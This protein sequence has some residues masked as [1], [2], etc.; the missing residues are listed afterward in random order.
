MAH[1][2]NR[3]RTAHILCAVTT[4]SAAPTLAQAEEQPPAP[5]VVDFPAL[6]LPPPINGLIGLP[7]TY[8]KAR[9]T[10]LALITREAEQ[11]GLPPALADAVVKV[12]SGF[13]PFAVGGIGEVG[14]M[15]VRPETAAMLGYQ[16]GATGLFDPETNVRLGVAY[17]ARAWQLANGDVCRALM[18]YRAGW[19]EERMTPF[20]VEYCRRARVHLAAIGS[21]LADE[22]RPTPQ[23]PATVVVA[24]P[25]QKLSPASSPG[26]ARLQSAAPQLAAAKQTP[27]EPVP[28]P[29]IRLASLGATAPAGDVGQTR[30]EAP[31]SNGAATDNNAARQQASAPRV[32]PP[33]IGSSKAQPHPPLVSMAKAEP[34][35]PAE[36][37]TGTLPKVQHRGGEAA[38]EQNL[39]SGSVKAPQIAP[40]APNQARAEPDVRS[41]S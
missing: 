4:L 22:A 18:K 39:R 25:N 26:A 40:I 16:G 2:C 8:T 14:L 17:L 20:S 19:G 9:S 31:K 3:L 12:E 38:P 23:E 37:R 7:Q 29:P 5:S 24:Q 6:P 15:Q 33:P 34:V 36:P 28:L 21:P 10:Y 35:K 13:K 41:P 27:V 32:T 1:N 11:K 30:S